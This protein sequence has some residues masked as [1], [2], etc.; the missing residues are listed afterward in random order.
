LRE[1][2]VREGNGRAIMRVTGGRDVM[3]KVMICSVRE[4]SFGSN[5]RRL[6]DDIE[7]NIVENIHSHLFNRAKYRLRL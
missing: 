5:R 4:Q 2:L 1:R 3:D 6:G 7:G